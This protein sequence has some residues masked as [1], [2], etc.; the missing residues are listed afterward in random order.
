VIVWRK[1]NSDGAQHQICSSSLQAVQS[2]DKRIVETA[3]SSE[4][5]S[6]ALRRAFSGEPPHTHT[7]QATCGRIKILHKD[8]IVPAQIGAQP[9]RVLALLKSAHLY[10]KRSREG[11]RAGAGDKL[12]PNRG[13]AGPNHIDG[14]SGGKRQIDYA[15]FNERT[16]VDNAYLGVF[17][18]V[19]IRDADDTTKGQSA[20]CGDEAIH[21]EDFAAG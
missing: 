8:R 18:V 1:A 5:S 14:V 9:V 10:R 15:A 4:F 12:E 17:A 7:I 19:Q 13:N 20:M 21:V 11:Q 2:H 16:A 3:L 6:E